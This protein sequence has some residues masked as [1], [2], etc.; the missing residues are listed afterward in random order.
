MKK[1]PFNLI[2]I[3]AGF[4]SIINI[5]DHSYSLTR[6]LNYTGIN[7]AEMRLRLTFLQGGTPTEFGEKPND[8]KVEFRFQYLF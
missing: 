1:E 5:N 6:Q 2:Y 8:Y 3:N 7:N 4:N